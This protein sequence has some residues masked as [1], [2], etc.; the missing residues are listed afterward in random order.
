M[1][2][3]SEGEVR[4]QTSQPETGPAT[5]RCQIGKAER[6]TILDGVCMGPVSKLGPGHAPK[7]STMPPRS[8]AM[9][10]IQQA[11]TKTMCVCGVAVLG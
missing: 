8:L 10:T 11:S 4:Q 6:V 9:S 5:A 2:E 1:A 3:A 7:R